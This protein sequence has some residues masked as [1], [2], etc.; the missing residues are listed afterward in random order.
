MIGL[1]RVHHR[2]TDSTNERA[3]D[4]ALAGAPHGTLVTAGEQTAG[5]GRQGRSW[6]A[7]PGAAL[8]MSVILRDLGEAQAHLP[9]AA[10]LAV[11]EACEKS[12]PVHCTIKWPN[13]V[14][15]EG[16]KLAG[17]LVEG[18]PQEGWAVLGIGVNLTTTEDA[19]PDELRGLATSLAAASGNPPPGLDRVLDNLLGALESRLAD[20][21]R[22][23]VAAWR[24]RDALRGRT[25]RWQAG[26]GTA[27][28]IDDSGALI[29]E[30]SSGRV[31]LD[32]GEVHLLH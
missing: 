1:P 10:A 6:V 28:G 13:D 8:L 19:F 15:V 14:W 2:T 3:K 30:T 24:E 9:L 23:I 7:P 25:I 5:R 29:V 21:P 12:A 18:R 27:T 17:I 16:R 22:R 32:A 20:T 31:T 26:E 11:C 4:L